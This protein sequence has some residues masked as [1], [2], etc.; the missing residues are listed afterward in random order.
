M[1]VGNALVRKLAKG[2]W[3]VRSSLPN[4]VARVIFTT[5]ET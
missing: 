1:A 3:E 4:R 5:A 2:L